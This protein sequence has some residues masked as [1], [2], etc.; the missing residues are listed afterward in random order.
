MGG[1]LAAELAGLEVL[2]ESIQDR[3]TNTTR[4]LVIGEK[5]CPPT[6]HDRTSILFSVTLQFP[7]VT[8]FFF[9]HI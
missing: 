3:A 1:K 5:T 2:E 7:I 8:Q 9:C 6:G 4:F